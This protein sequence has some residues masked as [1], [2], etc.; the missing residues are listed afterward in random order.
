VY[1]FLYCIH[2]YVSKLDIEDF[3]STFLYFGYTFIMVFL[4]FVLTGAFPLS[5][6]NVINNLPLSRFYWFL[7]LLLVCDQ[8]LQ[9]GEG[10]LSGKENIEKSQNFKIIIDNVLQQNLLLGYHIVVLC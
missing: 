1:F 2:Y 7:R 9:C 3:A 4:F 10:R 6:Q 5:N 8:D